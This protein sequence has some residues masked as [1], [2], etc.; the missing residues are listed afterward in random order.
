MPRN[1]CITLKGPGAEKRLAPR[2]YNPAIP[3]FHAGLNYHKNHLNGEIT[4][5]LPTG[6]GERFTLT[7]SDLEHAVL[8]NDVTPSK[9]E[10][11]ELTREPS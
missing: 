6:I 11:A 10:S 9:N 4:H 3:C 1:I 7:I 2:R 5:L 8:L